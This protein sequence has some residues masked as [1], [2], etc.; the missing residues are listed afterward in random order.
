MASDSKDKAATPPSKICPHCG[1]SF[2]SSTRFHKHV[3]LHQTIKLCKCTFP[4][5]NKSYKRPTHLTRHLATHVVNRPFKCTA[6]GCDKSFISK[7][8]LDRHTKSIHQ[9]M[10]CD[11]CGQRFRKRAKLERHKA[12]HEKRRSEAKMS[13][14]DCGVEIRMKSRHRCAK[15]KCK[16]CE[17]EFV[18]FADL[19]AH[20]KATHSR[21]HTCTDCGKH[22]RRVSDLRDHRSRVHEQAVLRCSEPGCQQ[23]FSTRPALLSHVKVYHLGIRRFNCKYCDQ[24]FAYKS[25][26]RRHCISVHE[27]SLSPAGDRS[28]QTAVPGR[29]A[30]A[31]SGSK[32]HRRAQR[33][34]I[35]SE[36]A[37]INDA[38][39]QMEEELETE[40][41]EMFLPAGNFDEDYSPAALLEDLFGDSLAVPATVS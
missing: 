26:L 31:T 30:T 13:C 39:Q 36:V 17:E 33:V 3:A 21:R 6:D 18:R 15:H 41:A 24:I 34:K 27:K 20:R 40:T 22:Y 1:K 5:C 28:D 4:G 9:G 2:P 8:K 16:D 32:R 14:P 35:S 37:S 19:V 7:Q 29:K 12:T 11:I 23:T 10:K 38:M 25:V